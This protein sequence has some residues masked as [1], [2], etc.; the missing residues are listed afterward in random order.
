MNFPLSLFPYQIPLIEKIKEGRAARRKR[1][2]RNPD[3]K[4]RRVRGIY[5]C[6]T[7]QTTKGTKPHLT[8]PRKGRPKHV[9]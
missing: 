7:F 5:H 8:L 4:R 6:E 3:K 1:P 9:G 2:R